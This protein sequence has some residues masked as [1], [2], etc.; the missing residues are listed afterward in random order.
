[1]IAGHKGKLDKVFLHKIVLFSWCGNNDVESPLAEDRA[2]CRHKAPRLEQRRVT[3]AHQHSFVH[4]LQSGPGVSLV[5]ELET[6]IST[7][8]HTVLERHSRRCLPL[9]RHLCRK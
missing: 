9:Y 1:M 2:T 7:L 3:R 8:T 5:G 4:V 6:G